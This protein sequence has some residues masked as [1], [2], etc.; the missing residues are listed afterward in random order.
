MNT[1]MEPAGRPNAVRAGVPGQ[2]RKRRTYLVLLLFWLL[3]VGGGAFGAKLYTDHL[4]RQIAA[5]IAAQ[6]DAR[7]IQVQQQYESQIA[8]LRESL[9]GDI[10]KLQE[11]IDSVNELLAFTKDSA[12][13]KTDNSNQL[14]TQLSELQKKLEALQK[15][16]DAL[17]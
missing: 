3:L 13:S 5:D 8:G 4:R 16:L 17:Q 12:S 14:Y 11:K 10:A 2:R 1:P 9:G 6:T 7:L 15:Q